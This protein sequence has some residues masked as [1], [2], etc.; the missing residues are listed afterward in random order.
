M[1]SNEDEELM[2]TSDTPWWWYYLA[3][4]GHWHKFEDDPDNPFTSDYIDKYYRKN[5]KAVLSTSSSNGHSKIDF[6]A[7]LQTDLIPRRQRR[8][9]RGFNIERSCSCFTSAPVYW[10]HIDAKCPYQLIPLNELTPEYRTVVGY[11]KDEGLLDRPFVSIRRIQ[12][13]D[14]W[15][16]Y[17]RKKKQLMRIKGVQEIQER[18]LFHGTDITNVDTICKYNFDVRLAGQHGHIFGKGVYF[19]RHASAADKYS[20]S[21]SNSGDTLGGVL[22]KGTKVIFLARVMIGKPVVGQ[23][24]FQKPDHG[25]SENSHDSC[26][27]DINHPNIFIIFDSN[28][29]YPEYLIEYR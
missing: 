26:V 13:L 18:R 10:E 5:S 15:E 4:C 1:W 22:L 20:K 29:I 16:L 7:M 19:A 14:L 24:R 28:Q 27:D 25:S 21:S 11:V 17:C 2:D 9:R 6:S 8:I 23:S 12:N 3:D